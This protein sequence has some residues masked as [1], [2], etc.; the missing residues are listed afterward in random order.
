MK[1]ATIKLIEECPER[2]KLGDTKTKN[3]M[4]TYSACK[5]W[6]ESCIRVI[7]C[8]KCNAINNAIRKIDNRKENNND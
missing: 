3:D 8:G 1:E 6:G 4:V 5:A 7:H 2:I